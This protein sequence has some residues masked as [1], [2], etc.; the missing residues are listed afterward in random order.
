MLKRT[1]IYLDDNEVQLLKKIS[2][3]QNVSMAELI[4]KGVQQICESY[5]HEQKEAMEILSAIQFQA[6]K[7]GLNQKS[8]LELAL[9]AQKE[10]RRE[11]K[12][13]SR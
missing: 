11:R 1:T 5:T 2:F 10:V 9:K 3:I 7:T 8:A 12:T 6:T 13:H 4:R